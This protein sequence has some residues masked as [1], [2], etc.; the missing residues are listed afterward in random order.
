MDIF[1]KNIKI[2]INLPSICKSPTN[3]RENKM[4][5]NISLHTVNK[6]LPL[7]YLHAGSHV[8]D[9]DR[10]TMNLSH[11]GHAV[12]IVVHDVGLPAQNFL[13][14]RLTVDGHDAGQLDG[15]MTHGLHYCS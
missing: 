1:T 6:D 11:S 3:D 10:E 14:G 7:P 12:G 2:I 8:T 15:G 9:E 4:G 5:A 13:S